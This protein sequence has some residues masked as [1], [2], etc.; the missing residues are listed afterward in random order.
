MAS[1][2]HIGLRRTTN[3]DRCLGELHT[4]A[5][6]LMPLSDPKPSVLGLLCLDKVSKKHIKLHSYKSEIKILTSNQFPAKQYMHTCSYLNTYVC[7]TRSTKNGPNYKLWEGKHFTTTGQV[8][9]YKYWIRGP[10]IF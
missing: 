5:T 2:E 4:H 10:R 9:T 7:V 1:Q 3:H 8:D 6:L